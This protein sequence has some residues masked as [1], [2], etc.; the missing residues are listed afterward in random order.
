MNVDKSYADSVIPHVSG[1][2]HGFQTI[3]ARS[4]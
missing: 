3:N 4:R 1:D 2:H